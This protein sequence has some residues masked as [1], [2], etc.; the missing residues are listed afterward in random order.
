M[1]VKRAR[2]KERAG[3]ERNEREGKERKEG[4]ERGGRE[5]RERRKWS[6][7]ERGEECEMSSWIDQW[8]EM[9]NLISITEKVLWTNDDITKYYDDL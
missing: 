7:G 8:N 4:K 1:K 5:K 3:R 6:E 9:E 2:E